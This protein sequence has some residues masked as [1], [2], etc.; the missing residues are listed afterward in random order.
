MLDRPP[1]EVPNRL[2][3]TVAE[4][5][6]NLRK[7]DRDN[8]GLIFEAGNLDECGQPYGPDV[9]QRLARQPQRGGKQAVNRLYRPFL[10]LPLPF[11]LPLPGPS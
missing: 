3:E 9:I 5:E 7:I 1:R 6:T 8:F 10:P 4:I 2:F 11:P